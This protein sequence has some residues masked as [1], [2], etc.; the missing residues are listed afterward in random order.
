MHQVNQKSSDKIRVYD[1]YPSGQS[2]WLAT[3]I[4][5]GGPI[6]CGLIYIFGTNPPK[7][8]LACFGVC[9]GLIGLGCFFTVKTIINFSGQELTRQAH[10]LGKRPI[11]VRHFAFSA[12]DAVIL[13][14]RANDDEGINY[15]LVALKRTSGRKMWVSHFQAT[16]YGR[17]CGPAE[18]L[19]LQ[20]SQDMQL[21]LKKIA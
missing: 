17:V 14:Q 13:K 12:F 9:F 4:G 6:I 18:D 15:W 7:M 21:P 2:R 3:V 5:L 16:A 1:W 19:A 20:L 8:A 10:I 11:W